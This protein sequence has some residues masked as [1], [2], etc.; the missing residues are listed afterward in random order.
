ME[1]VA[2]V[3]VNSVT[4]YNWGWPFEEDYVSWGTK[5][6]QRREQWTQALDSLGV[7]FFPNASIGWDDSPRFP[8]KKADEIVHYN[9]S[10]ES[11]AAFLQKTK[12]YVDQRPGRP[13]LITI[14]S[15][16]EWVEGSY[17]LPDMKNGF[18]YLNAVKQ[19]MNGEYE[20]FGNKTNQYYIM[21]KRKF[22]MLG[23][24]FLSLT[25]GA[26]QD[27]NEN[28]II[29]PEPQPPV[30]MG[31][32]TTL[33][34]PDGG[35]KVE[36]STEGNI[37]YTVSHN[38]VTV[39]NASPVSMTLDDGQTW[40]KGSTFIG[41]TKESVNTTIDSPFYIRKS[42]NDI[43]NELTLHFSE[44]FRIVFR[45]YNEGM[46][47][48]FES[49][50]K[51]N[52]KVLSEEVDFSFPSSFTMTAALSPGATDTWQRNA[53]NS[54][55]NFYQ[56]DI[57]EISGGC[58]L[59]MLPLM[60]KCEGKILCIAEANVKNYPSMFIR[61]MP[62][63]H[64]AGYQQERVRSAY[65]DGSY[66]WP[67][68]WYKYIASCEGSMTFPWRILM[69][70]DKE[71]QLLDNDMIYK[72]APARSKLF[73]TSWIK[74]GMSTWD[75][76]TAYSLDGVGTPGIHLENYIYHINF[77]KEMGIPYITI[78]AGSINMWGTDF[79]Y[80]SC[81]KDVIEQARKSNI[82]VWVWMEAA[83]FSDVLEKADNSTF[84]Y[85]FRRLSNDGIKGIK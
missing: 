21:M 57:K 3:G 56:Y 67:S 38:G 37:T 12:E 41:S 17:L 32:D 6:M 35:L 65:R 60:V 84:E 34:S 7:P 36:I 77:A 9:D 69:V 42:V 61:K 39:V 1:M 46:A 47:Y 24:L 72:L 76:M 75:W 10:P 53:N 25:F 30:A 18:G 83:F 58:Q 73:D 49:E 45:A 66:K 44:E 62:G 5:A 50:R 59:A 79:S 29:E 74:P 33:E 4:K 52:F 55:E 2:T 70:M 19:V 14:N 48:H 64:L 8:N 78:D 63:N 27:S 43:Y 13:K 82:G 20:N 80:D 22:G 85:I 15:W 40:G 71:S 51:K 68:E 23:L 11:F 16:N 81:L 54:Y 26:C 31:K 28:E